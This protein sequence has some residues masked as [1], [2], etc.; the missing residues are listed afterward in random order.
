MSNQNAS[1]LDL[2]IAKVAPVC[3]CVFHK[4]IID[5]HIEYY[6]ILAVLI[7]IKNC[8]AVLNSM[9]FII[10]LHMSYIKIIQNA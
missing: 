10:F 7:F 5:R 1:I 4:S 6:V 2:C 8:F 3:V 9:R